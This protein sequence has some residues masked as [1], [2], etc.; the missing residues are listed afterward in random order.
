MPDIHCPNCGSPLTP[1]CFPEFDC[2]YCGGKVK[3]PRILENNNYGV[4]NET[5]PFGLSSQ[6]IKDLIFNK[7]KLAEKE[8]KKCEI[9]SI[10]QFFLPMY[11]SDSRKLQ[12]CVNYNVVPKSMQNFVRNLPIQFQMI[13]SV[14]NG[15]NKSFLVSKSGNKIPILGIDQD[16]KLLKWNRIIL[17]S[18]YHGEFT[19]RGKTYKWMMDGRGSNVYCDPIT[20]KN[21]KFQKE[22]LSLYDEEEKRDL[23]KVN[24]TYI[25][26]TLL[27][28]VGFF[29]IYIKNPDLLTTLLPFACFEIALSFTYY[30]CRGLALF[31]KGFV[32]M[33]IF[34]IMI[35]APLIYM[36][37]A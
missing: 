20:D 33:L 22:D 19:Y 17:M 15:F 36:V 34:S 14:I 5:V 26:F 2:A 23:K 32:V 9:T 37:L 12:P 6:T 27:I 16:D 10:K 29:I 3:N 28:I 24:I 8:Y 7:T 13:K 4:I 31:S 1:R 25:I 35:L 18:F 21:A 30:F 11:T